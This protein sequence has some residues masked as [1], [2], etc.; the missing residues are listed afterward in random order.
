[1]QEKNDM[2]G[3]Q[4]YQKLSAMCAR[5]EHCQYEMTEKMRQWGIDSDS[6][7]QV[8]ERLVQERYVDDERYCRAF[9]S[10]KIRYS[11]WGRR[12]IEQALWQKHIPESISRPLL[13]AIDDSEYVSILK[14]MIRQKI[15]STTARSDYDR[16]I[17]VMK[18]AMSRGYTTDIIKQCI[19]ADY[20]DALTD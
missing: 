10:D 18:W 5:G 1:M 2:T 15:R 7:A 11:R 8:I 6:Q 4:A 16:Y 20:D 9:I 17:K 14:P 19:T 12:K 13:D 3:L